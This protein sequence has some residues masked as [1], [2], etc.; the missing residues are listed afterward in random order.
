M[1]VVEE[2]EDDWVVGLVAG[3]VAMMVLV[4]A[5]KRKQNFQYNVRHVVDQERILYNKLNVSKK[6]QV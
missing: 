4:L 2:V 5:T 6:I 1:V 3:L